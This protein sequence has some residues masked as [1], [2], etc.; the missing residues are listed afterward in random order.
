LSSKLARRSISSL[1]AL[2][3]KSSKE[4]SPFSISCFMQTSFALFLSN[5]LR[6]QEANVVLYFQKISDCQFD[7]A[8]FQDLPLFRFFETIQIESHYDINTR[9]AN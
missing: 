1:S 2:M 9:R 5:F 6:R 8:N 4:N 3:I 7:M